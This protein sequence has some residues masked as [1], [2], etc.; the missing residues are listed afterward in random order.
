MHEFEPDAK[1]VIIEG[2]Q[3]MINGEACRTGCHDRLRHERPPQLMAMGYLLAW[4][5]L[6]CQ[7]AVAE[8]AE[9]GVTTAALLLR[10]AIQCIS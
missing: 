4:S 1:R 7:T 3:T 5:G 8:G 2:R 10:E 9:R 6:G